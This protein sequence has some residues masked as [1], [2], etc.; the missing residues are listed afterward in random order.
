MNGTPERVMSGD[1][2]DVKAIIGTEKKCSKCGKIKMLSDFCLYKRAKDGHK[3]WCRMCEKEYLHNWRENNPEKCKGYAD[4]WHK[5]N[6]GKRLA[7]TVRWQKNNPEKCRE[8]CREWRQ[9]NAEKVKILNKKYR[10]ERRSTLAGNLNH[11]FSSALYIALRG[12]KSG[13]RWESL[14]GYTLD[15]LK[16]HL[17]KHFKL[18]MTWDNIGEWHID[19][20]TPV[21]VFNFETPED[22]D[23]KRCWALKNLQPLW[24]SENLRKYNKIDKPFQPALLLSA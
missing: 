4:K 21:S 6:P 2:P 13:R 3:P 24:A 17:E 16:V 22:I 23:F 20:I 19:H 9:R 15:E 1:V 8:R 14:V 18:G 12:N 10:D 11:R 5:N 7:C